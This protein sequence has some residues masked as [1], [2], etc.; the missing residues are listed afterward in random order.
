VLVA[1]GPAAESTAATVAG[2]GALIV[3][4]VDQPTALALARSALDARLSLLLRPG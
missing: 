3:L 4:A 1:A 2:E